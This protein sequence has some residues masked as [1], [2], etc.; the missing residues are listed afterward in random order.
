MSRGPV[1]FN[2][3]GHLIKNKATWFGRWWVPD[4]SKRKQMS[5]TLGRIDE[6]TRQEAQTKMRDLI[7]VT[8]EN[9]KHVKAI[10]EAAIGF[11]FTQYEK[12]KNNF[13]LGIACEMLVC[14]DLHMK[15]YEVFRP[16]SAVSS[17]DLIALKDGKSTRLEVKSGTGPFLDL[18]RKIGKFDLL[19]I[20]GESSRID[21]YPYHSLGDLS[22]IKRGLGSGTTFGQQSVQVA[23]EAEENQQC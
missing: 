23:S 21:Y 17:C 2:Q 4:G 22:K 16:I 10:G 5:A 3:D 7:R 19:A 1:G 12:A 20:V 14:A 9:G 18:R 15:G 11:D 6:M 8:N 13:H